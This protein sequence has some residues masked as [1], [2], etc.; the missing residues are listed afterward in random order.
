MF[1]CE[2]AL[3]SLSLPLRGKPLKYLLREG[4]RNYTVWNLSESDSVTRFIQIWMNAEMPLFTYIRKSVFFFRSPSIL[5]ETANRRRVIEMRARNARANIFP[6]DMIFQM[7]RD[8]FMLFIMLLLLF[9]K[10]NISQRRHVCV[11]AR[12]GSAWINILKSSEERK[13]KIKSSMILFSHWNR[14]DY[15]ERKKK[16]VIISKHS[17]ENMV[18]T[19]AH[20]I[21]RFFPFSIGFFAVAVHRELRVFAELASHFCS[22][23][24]SHSKK[25][26]NRS[27]ERKSW[28][29][30]SNNSKNI[31]E[32]WNS[33]WVVFFVGCHH[34]HRE[35]AAYKG[36]AGKKGAQ[37]KRE[38]EMK[39]E[40]ER[41]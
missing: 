15:W 11:S 41:E 20:T 5:S 34:F 31:S 40:N 37:K 4:E 32:M 22:I 33:F 12:E 1:V 27:T 14:P 10:K 8:R 9:E 26:G 23:K 25:N 13:I 21:F 29:H 30:Q 36:R 16:I 38:D 3:F 39:V 18:A 6:N 28:L 17:S 7:K 19:V 35:C 2:C 24:F